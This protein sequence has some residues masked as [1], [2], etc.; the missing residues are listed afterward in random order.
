MK[1]QISELSSFVY[2]TLINRIKELEERNKE[3][4]KKFE[5]MNNKYE[6]KIK[7]DK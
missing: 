5:E 6:N 4:E 7:N 1:T 3:Y 2:N